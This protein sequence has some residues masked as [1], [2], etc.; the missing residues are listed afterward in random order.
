MLAY[1]AVLHREA[2]PGGL[3]TYA[4]EL[5]AG[6]SLAWLVETLSNSGEFRAGAQTANPFPLD[7]APPMPFTL[8]GEELQALWGR[9]TATWSGLGQTDPHWSVL[10]EA[11]FL[12]ERMDAAALAV[13]HETGEGEM[14]RLEAWLRRSGVALPAG[15]VCMEYGCGVGRVTRA[16]ARRTG[17]V[18]AF[19]VSPPHLRAAAAQIAEDGITNVEFVQVRGPADLLALDGADLFFSVISLQHSAPPIILDVLER[20]FAGLRPGGLAFFQVPTYAVDYAWPAP[21]ATAGEMEMHFVPQHVIFGAA[22]RAGLRVLE[23]QPD[24]CI[25]RTGDWISNTFLLQKG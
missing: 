19:D 14:H 12:A 13:F 17:R 21:A 18:V 23:V 9:V 25:G 2:D 24:W 20:A 11:R 4:A 5:R 6:R 15:A 8:G 10:T 7:T 16:L 1:R 3:T 22:H